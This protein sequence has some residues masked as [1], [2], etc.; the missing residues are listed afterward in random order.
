MDSQNEYRPRINENFELALGEPRVAQKNKDLLK[1]LVEISKYF[2][3]RFDLTQAAGGNSSVKLNKKMFI[4]SSGYSLSE[5]TLKNGYTIVDNDKLVNFLHS[6]RG[7]KITDSIE[8]KSFKILKDSTLDGGNPSIETLTHSIM[9]KFTIHIHPVAV[10]MVSVNRKS[11]E[12]F[13]KI[14][15][16]KRKGESI[17]YV[18][19]RTPGISLATEIINVVSVEQDKLKRDNTI[20]VFLENHGLICSS[21]NKLELIQSVEKIVKQF[22]NYLKI[23]LSRY[24]LT[25][26]ISQILW[27]NSYE[28]LICCYSEDAIL[29]KFINLKNSK[30]FIKPLNPDQ[31]LYC[32]ESPLIVGSSLEKGIKSYLKKYKT[33]PRVLIVKKDVY[34]VAP[35]VLKAKEIEDVFK[36]HL[37]FN[38]N[39]AL[40]RVLSKNEI[41]KLDS[42]NPQKNRLRFWFDYVE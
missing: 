18:S 16:T 41:K 14:F 4:K 39:G 40:N 8:K 20:I 24:K 3:Q 31:L 12:I 35:N 7:N 26:E 9:K 5:V 2:G 13:N 33:Y 15:S 23:N 37:Y 17:Y 10:N 6:A 42:Y 36:S 11:R 22:E 1:D 30:N 28:N 38:S 25:T 32:G 29:T 27:K 19:Y 21:D 34:L